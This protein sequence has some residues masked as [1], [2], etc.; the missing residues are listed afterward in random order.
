EVIIKLLNDHDVDSYSTSAP[1]QE[2]VRTILN[3][4]K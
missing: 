3:G 1:V 4:G 2:L